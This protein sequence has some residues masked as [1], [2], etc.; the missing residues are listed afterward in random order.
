MSEKWQ[1]QCHGY[2]RAA[3][4]GEVSHPGP[5]NDTRE[6]R[7]HYYYTWWRGR[8]AERNGAKRV[9]QEENVHSLARNS[10]RTQTKSPGS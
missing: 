4:V 7:Y 8:Q 1:K 5:G 10:A 9:V 3:R 6:L 2:Y